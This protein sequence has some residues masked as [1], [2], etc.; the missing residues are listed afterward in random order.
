MANRY[1]LDSDFLIDHLR[2]VMAAKTF[3]MG[4]DGDLFVSVVTVTELY[5]G[6][7]SPRH[8]SSI[9]ALLQ[10]VMVVAVDEEIA[11]R[12]GLTR[13]QYRNSHGTS[14]PDAL[15][16]ATAEQIGATLITFN[17]RH[18]PMIT[19]LLVPYER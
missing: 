16:A 13:A 5:S 7:R 15:I 12:A 18:F 3:F 10:Q 19:N 11:K 8:Q 17:Q 14:T 1:L 9:E 6:V 2:G 4:L